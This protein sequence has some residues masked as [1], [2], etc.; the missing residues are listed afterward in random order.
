MAGKVK[1][2]TAA[3]AILDIVGITANLLFLTRDFESLCKI[4]CDHVQK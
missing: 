2:L 1:F 4:Q 3:A